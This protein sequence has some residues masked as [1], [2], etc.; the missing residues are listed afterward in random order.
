MARTDHFFLLLIFL[1]IIFPAC[2]KSK[3]AYDC[4]SYSKSPVIKVEGPNTGPVNQD[5]N[6]TITYGIDNGCG[7]FDHY[8]KTVNGNTTTIDVVGKYTGCICT[9]V[10]QEL[11]SPYT[12][13]ATSTGTYYLEFFHDANTVVKDTIMIQ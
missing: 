1:T 11:Q 2:S 5:I 12:F 6:L 3:G 10:Y 7:Q 13:K 9:Q 4:I 8:E